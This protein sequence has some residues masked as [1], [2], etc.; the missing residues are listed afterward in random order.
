ME[1]IIIESNNVFFVNNEWRYERR[2]VNLSTF[3]I[4]YEVK[5]GLKTKEEAVQ[6]KEIDDK[7]FQKDLKKIKRI[8]NAEY[9]FKEYVDYWLKTIFIHNYQNSTKAIGIWATKNLIL[10]SVEQDILLPYVTADYIDNIIRRCIPICKYAGVTSIKYMK[11]ILYD[12]YIHGL[13]NIDLKERLMTLPDIIPNIQ[14]LTGEQLQ[15][16]LYVA[17]KHDCCYFEILLALFAGL[18]TGEIRGLK[19]SDFDKKK[20]TLRISRQYTTNY[21]LAESNDNF[22]YSYYSEEKEPK[23]T[24]ARLLKIPKFF[25]SE[26][27]SKKKYNQVIIRNAKKRGANVEEEYISLSHTGTRKKKT[28]LLAAVKRVCKEALVPEISVHT[29]RHQFATILLEKEVPL[30]QISHLLGHNSVTTTLNIYCEI[31]D[32]R[33]GTK[34]VI[35][36]FAPYVNDGE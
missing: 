28:A 22:E 11:H 33:E 3:T 32:A 17:Q 5:K 9:T 31:M 1:E 29:L 35:S 6:F 25:F 16:F 18:R 7:Q 27:E 19:Y 14:L 13:I 2:I 8:A 26:L 34:D 30:E 15:K 24:S 23:S 10:P 20:Q 12:A 36:T 4:S 21:H